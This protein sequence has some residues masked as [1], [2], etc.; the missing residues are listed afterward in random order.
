MGAVKSKRVSIKPFLLEYLQ[1][2]G[3]QLGTDDLSEILTTIITEHRRA[4]IRVCATSLQ[5]ST[6]PAET[7]AAHSNPAEAVQRTDDAALLDQLSG[8]FDSAT[9]A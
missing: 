9:A 8:I 6:A 5:V 4:G 2:V 1:Q 7:P 3:T